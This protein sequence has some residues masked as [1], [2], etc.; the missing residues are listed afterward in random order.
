MEYFVR[1]AISFYNY[2][3]FI[4]SNLVFD[5]L[6]IIGISRECAKYKIPYF[7]NSNLPITE[8]IPDFLSKNSI[9]AQQGFKAK[10]ASYT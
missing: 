9:S 1:V 6:E 10:N 2:R 8:P 5:I 4:I 7:P 3:R